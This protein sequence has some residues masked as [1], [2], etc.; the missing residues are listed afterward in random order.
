MK[1]RPQRLELLK[2]MSLESGGWEMKSKVA[3]I[4]SLLGIGAASA[5]AVA[6]D[7]RQPVK[8]EAVAT[9]EAATKPAAAKPEAAT[10]Q[11]AATKPGAVTKEDASPKPAGQSMTVAGEVVELSCYMAKEAKGEQHK[12]C[13]EAC[14]K[15]GAPIG[16]LTADG[17][18]FLMVEDHNAKQPYETLKTKAAQQ[19]KVTGTLQERGGL[20]AI[21]VTSVM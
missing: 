6:D 2:A 21:V 1:A 9:Q 10:K 12:A 5:F 4:V 15:G 3:L 11:E 14:I 18:L 20:R 7:T 13:A 19:A 8:Q 16:I 17:K